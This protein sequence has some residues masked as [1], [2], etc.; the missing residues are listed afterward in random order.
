M[1]LDN[2]IERYLDERIENCY[3][4]IRK[5]DSE[6]AGIAERRSEQKKEYQAICEKMDERDRE[7]LAAIE[8]DDFYCRSVEEKRLYWQGC[9]DCIVLLKSLKILSGGTD[10]E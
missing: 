5:S 4:S 3:E 9:Y 10:N 8:H 7:A 6:Y 2:C 1:F